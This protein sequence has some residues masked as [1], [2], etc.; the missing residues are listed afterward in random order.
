MVFVRIPLNFHFL[1]LLPQNY[2]AITKQIEKRA[3]VKWT[4]RRGNNAELH[5][6]VRLSY[7][8]TREGSYK[9]QNVVAN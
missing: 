6:E 7:Q 2:I 5:S 8:N 4:R 1:N 3:G 9:L